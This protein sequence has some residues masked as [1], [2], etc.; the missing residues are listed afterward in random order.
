MRNAALVLGSIGGIVGMVV[1]FAG[2]GYTAFI[3]WFG[4]IDNVAEQDE[5]VEL[6][7]AVSVLSPLL[8][9][10]GGAMARSLAVAGGVLLL[11]SAVGMYGAFGFTVFTVS[12]IAMCGLGAALALSARQPSS[13]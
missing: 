12:Q 10:A 7:R 3:E 11:V 1:G 5:N 2:F 4:E 13:A 6:I 8:A 9:I